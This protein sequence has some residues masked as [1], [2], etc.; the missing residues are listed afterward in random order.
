[1]L[2]SRKHRTP[3]SLIYMKREEKKTDPMTYNKKQKKTITKR[4]RKR[5]C[6]LEGNKRKE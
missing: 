4:Q 6:C 1:M 5:Y 2:S 3:E